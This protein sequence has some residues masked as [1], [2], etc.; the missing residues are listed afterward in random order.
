LVQRET[1]WQVDPTQSVPDEGPT[2]PP[3]PEEPAA[4]CDCND[5]SPLNELKELAEVDDALEGWYASRILLPAAMIT[6]GGVVAVVSGF[7]TIML[8]ETGLGCVLAPVPVA[9]GAFG[10]GLAGEGVHYAIYGSFY[11]PCKR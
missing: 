10:L 2:P 1:D 5:E 6:T 7:A 11:V 9:T 4:Q 8:C 3:S